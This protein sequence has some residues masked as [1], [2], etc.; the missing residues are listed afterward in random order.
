[1][2]DESAA[3]AQGPS[4]CSSIHVLE[5]DT[6]TGGATNSSPNFNNPDENDGPAHSSR[7]SVSAGGEPAPK[8]R[9]RRR[10]RTGMLMLMWISQLPSCPSLPTDSSP[11]T[12]ALQ[13]LARP[14]LNTGIQAAFNANGGVFGEFR[15]YS[16]PISSYGISLMTRD[17]AVTSMAVLRLA[18]RRQPVVVTHVTVWDLFAPGQHHQQKVS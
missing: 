5:N 9:K 13:Q 17:T 8:I 6:T 12:I 14:K 3:T 7:D 4:P 10:V 15:Y 11:S 1:M 2:S 16:F 18:K